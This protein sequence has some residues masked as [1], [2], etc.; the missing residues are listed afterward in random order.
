MFE[1]VLEREIR[2][3]LNE[4]SCSLS[5]KASR[6]KRYISKLLS[7]LLLPDLEGSRYD[8]KHS[9]LVL[10]NSERP[11]DLFCPNPTAF[12]QLG[13]NGTPQCALYIMGEIACACGG[14]F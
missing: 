13:R 7:V 9:P 12:F 5:S 3:C 10:L 2:S 6:E 4:S 11:N 8:L 14:W 1:C